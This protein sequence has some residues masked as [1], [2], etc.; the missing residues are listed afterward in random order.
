M[1]LYNSKRPRE[2]DIMAFHAQVEAGI[3]QHLEAIFNIAY[4]TEDVGCRFNATAILGFAGTYLR[5]RADQQRLLDFLTAFSS[6]T[7]WP[8]TLD[9]Q[10]LLLAWSTSRVA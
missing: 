7:G 10:R 3:V 8:T 6:Q 5:D 2:M 1:K 4:G 9:Q